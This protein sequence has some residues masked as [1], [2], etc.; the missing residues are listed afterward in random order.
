MKITVNGRQEEIH[1][2]CRSYLYLEQLLELLELAQANDIQVIVNGKHV[3]KDT[4]SSAQV[5]SADRVRITV[6][7]ADITP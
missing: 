2:G 3:E 7:R 1:L 6:C 4:F 5:K